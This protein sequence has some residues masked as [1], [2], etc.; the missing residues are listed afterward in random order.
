MTNDPSTS[1]T[2]GTPG[3][4]KPLPSAA[5]AQ[6]AP[7]G[8]PIPHEPVYEPGTGASQ[9]SAGDATGTK[10]RGPGE[11]DGAEPQRV[12]RAGVVWV[13]TVAGLLLL[14]LLIIFIAQ[15]TA[16]VPL[17]YFGWEGTVLLGLALFVAA[18]AGGILVAIAG[19][20]R[21]IQLRSQGH[22]RRSGRKGRAG[23]RG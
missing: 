12:T 13:A 22:R 9:D 3:A 10:R 23:K 20:A 2:A 16:N 4:G 6:P 11:R 18:V 8:Q 7:G 14:V 19:A 21:I 15:N 5:A 17:R 1:P